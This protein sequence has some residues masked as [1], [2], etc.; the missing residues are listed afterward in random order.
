M[1]RLRW[2]L[3][4]LVVVTVAAAPSF[5]P[6]GAGALSGLLRDATARGEVPGV[7]VAVV[8]KD[9][10]P[11]QEAFG[12]SSTLSK[13]PMTT[14]PI[15]AMA[16]MTKPITSAAI[17]MLVDAGNL[18]LDDDVAWFLPKYRNPVVVTDFNAADGSFKTRP[19]KGPITI[20]QLL[21]HTSGL[22]YA[23]VDPMLTTIVQKSGKA[24]TDLLL[25]DPGTNWHYGPSTRVLGDVVAAVSGQPLDVF[26]TQRIFEPLG[27]HD[28]SYLVPPAKYSRVV[29]TSARGAD[30]KFVE[31]PMP[32]TL[33]ASV[34]GDGG[35]YGTASDYG[36]FLRMLLNKGTAGDRRLLSEK[37]VKAMFDNQTGGV[38][39]QTMHSANLT[40]SRDFPLGAGKDHWGLGF[41]LAAESRP[42]HRATGSGT[43]AG[44]FNTH[45]FIDPRTGIAV[46]VM[47]QTL[48][49]YDEASMQVYERVEEAVYRN[50]K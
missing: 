11:Y 25:F 30:G 38:A 5:P 32:A 46:I 2:V 4:L 29:A 22:G 17:M 26:L 45:F 14:D 36:L 7:V 43:W 31:Q 8:S 40:L 27:M 33:P 50:L 24:E 23:F 9:A 12:V 44:V 35:L 18:S 39:V 1:N 15:F 20:R 41:Q 37:S 42:N 21:T 47:M 10:T 13:R 3:L 28:T 16:S 48:P 34:A 6:Q 19:A 49:F